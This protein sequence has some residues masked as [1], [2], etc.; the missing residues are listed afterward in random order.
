MSRIAQKRQNTSI[1]ELARHCGLAEGTISRAL[2]N[3]PDIALKTRERVQQAARELGYRPNRLAQSM[4]T[5]RTYTVGLTIPD[6]LNPFFPEVAR[7]VQDVARDHDYNVFLCNTDD[8]PE[9]EID[10]LRSLAA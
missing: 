2:N 8:N 9:V 1:A 4:V 7:G 10:V 5:Q 6:I 3:Y